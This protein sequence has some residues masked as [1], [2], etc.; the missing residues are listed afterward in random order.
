MI[1]KLKGQ[2]A[3]ALLSDLGRHRNITLTYAVLTL[4]RCFLTIRDR[5][6]IVIRSAKVETIPCLL[7]VNCFKVEVLR[8]KN[9]LLSQSSTE[10]LI[11]T[12]NPFVVGSIPAR[13]T[14]Y[15]A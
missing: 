9:N 1:K 14:K 6:S 2:S 7:G 12:F 15:K 10:C 8:N 5:F 13:P 11:R 4:R 3:F